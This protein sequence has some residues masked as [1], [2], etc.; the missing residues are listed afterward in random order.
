MLHMSVY[1]LVLWMSVLAG[2]LACGWLVDA[3]IADR[4]SKQPTYQPVSQE[5][6]QVDS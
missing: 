2:I 6:D 1:G 3:Y 4:R 5:T